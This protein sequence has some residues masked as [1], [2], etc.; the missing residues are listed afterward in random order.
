MELPRYVSLSTTPV[1]L[2]HD[3]RS[4]KHAGSAARVYVHPSGKENAE[5]AGRVQTNLS[6]RPSAI[7]SSAC[8]SYEDVIELAVA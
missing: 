5:G 3:R 4:K 2:V 7:L 6:L 1:D 8:T